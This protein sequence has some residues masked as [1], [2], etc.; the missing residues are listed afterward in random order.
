MPEGYFKEKHI[1]PSIKILP[2]RPAEI[3]GLPSC[4]RNVRKFPKQ[5][6]HAVPKAVQTG[7]QVLHIG[8]V[9]TPGL[10]GASGR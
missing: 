8:G 10:I 7:A 6:I 1:Y 2:C 5:L 9:N 4:L 3:N